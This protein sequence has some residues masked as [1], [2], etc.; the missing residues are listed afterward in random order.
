[1]PLRSGRVP[2]RIEGMGR[3]SLLVGGEGGA[4]GGKGGALGMDAPDDKSGSMP[5]NGARG[6]ERSGLPPTAN[7]IPRPPSGG[8]EEHPAP[9]AT[10]SAMQSER[11]RLHIAQV[12]CIIDTY[13]F[14]NSVCCTK[15]SNSV[16]CTKRGEKVATRH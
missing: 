9:G 15:F 6:A 13:E 2:I 5:H 1:M 12:W 3:E 7:T 11:G 16:C 8:A 4:L 14:S 10:L